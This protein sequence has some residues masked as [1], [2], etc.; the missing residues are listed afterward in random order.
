MLVF[1]IPLKS[2]KVSKSWMHACQ[3]LERTVRSACNQTS[4]QF[5]VVVICHEKPEIQFSHPNLTIIP[6]DF[7]LPKHKDR[8]ARGLTD[9]GRKVLKGLIY[10]RQFDPSHA[11][12]VDADDCVS[13]RLAAFVEQNNQENGWFVQSG[14]KYQEGSENIYYKRWN[15]Y[16]M[17][18]TASILRYDLLDLPETPEYNR[19]YGSYKLYLDHQ[20]VRDYM[21]QKE[22]PLKP[23]PF[24]ASVYILGNENMSGNSQNLSFSFLNR[25]R[26]NPKIR[27]EFGLYR[28]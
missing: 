16:R 13:R 22:H 2:A 14:Y 1:I 10:A 28:F 15:F 20:K 24:P 21:K 9:K 25:R 23:I 7:P 12:F 26:L 27:E 5:Q 3:L 18:G 4:N 17:S 6:V 8:I 11:M 19:G